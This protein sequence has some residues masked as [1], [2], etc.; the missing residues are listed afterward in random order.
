MKGILALGCI[1][2][3]AGCASPP[4][5][6]T[7]PAM[8]HGDGVTAVAFSPDGSFL[9]SADLSGE[10]AAWDPATGRRLWAVPSHRGAVRTAAV[11]PDGSLVVTVGE[12]FAVVARRSADGGEAWRGKFPVGGMYPTDPVAFSPD[13]TLVAVGGIDTKVHVLSTKDG[14]DVWTRETEGSTALCFSAD[15]RRIFAGSWSCEVANLD[16]VARTQSANWVPPG[17]WRGSGFG[18]NCLALSPDGGLL[19]DGGEDGTVRLWE[20]ADGKLR[21]TVPGK[22][23]GVVAVGFLDG[24]ATV[25][26]A[27][28]DGSFARM[29]LDGEGWVPAGSLGD[30]VLEDAAIDPVHARGAAGRRSGA[31]R[32]LDLGPGGGS[33]AAREQERGHPRPRRGGPRPRDDPDRGGSR[34]RGRRGGRASAPGP[35]GGDRRTRR[36]DPPG[37]RHGGA[38]AAGGP[39]HPS[40]RL[41]D[42]PPLP[43]LRRPPAG[44][45]D[46]PRRRC[47][48]PAAPAGAAA[49]PRGPRRD[50]GGE[51]PR[52][53]RGGPGGAPPGPRECIIE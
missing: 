46:R 6:D 4:R 28:A 47:L 49:R 26:A 23:A 10:V 43:R 30:G 33:G 17:A 39:A 29:A 40:R 14:S 41:R 7:G 5:A 3:L 27:F 21:R 37:A 36:R 19:A 18:V 38:A 31:V 32:L 24:G 48:P 15:G 52:D 2:L 9:V 42:G 22:G 34:L 44:G 51:A 20:T 13:G 45:Q 35:R 11:A 12:D 1:A 8:R 25:A 53:R 16:L 50:P